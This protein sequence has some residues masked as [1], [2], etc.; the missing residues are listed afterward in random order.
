[1]SD[2]EGIGRNLARIS[3]QQNKAIPVEP[4]GNGAEDEKNEACHDVFAPTSCPW[5]R[6]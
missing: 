3:S 4:L 6:L 2:G 5:A 1:M